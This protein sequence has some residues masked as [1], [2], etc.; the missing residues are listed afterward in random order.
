MDDDLHGCCGRAGTMTLRAI[1]AALALGVSG[2]GG[3]VS[4]TNGGDIVTGSER[5]GWDQPASDA[6][7][8]ATFRYALYV[9]ET[10]S[11]AADVSCAAAQSSGGFA[12]TSQLPPMSAG[13][14]A[15]QVAA[16]ILDGTVVRE[17]SRSAIVRVIK[18]P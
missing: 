7:E 5:F 14:H 9:D 3:S 17:S 11:E 13:A 4:T 6:G 2:C 18:R 1:L 12:C 8:L 16:F 10:R 15:L